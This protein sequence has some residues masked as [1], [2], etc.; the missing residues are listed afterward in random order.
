MTGRFLD[1]PDNRVRESPCPIDL[2]RKRWLRFRPGDWLGFEGNIADDL[3]HRRVEVPGKAKGSAEALTGPTS[4]EGTRVQVHN[5][6]GRRGRPGATWAT[7]T[8][9]EVEAFAFKWTW[10]GRSSKHFPFD[11]SGPDEA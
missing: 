7:A 9:D 1:P 4:P 5:R 2:R 6:A 10:P 11:W 8:E 3:G